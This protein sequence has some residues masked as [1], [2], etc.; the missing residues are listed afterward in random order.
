MRR[1]TSQVGFCNKLRNAGNDRNMGLAILLHVAI[2]FYELVWGHGLMAFPVC[3][4]RHGHG[5]VCIV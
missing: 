3:H 4:G 1:S 2:L 5:H